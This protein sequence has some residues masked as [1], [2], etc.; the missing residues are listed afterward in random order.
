[1][2]V[3]DLY[4]KRRKRE[5]GQIPDVYAYDA[6]PQTFRMQ[7]FHIWGDAIGIPYHSGYSNTDR[8]QQTY[9]SIA[10]I[11]RRE[12]GKAVLYGH[13]DS[14]DAR[15]AHEEMKTWLLNET[16]VDKVL[17]GIEASFVVIERYCSQNNY[18]P[19]RDNGEIAKAAIDE[20][21]TRFNEHGL[22]YQY[23]HGKIVRTDSTFV[24]A[25]AVIPAL[26]I[27][28]REEYANAQTEFLNAFEHYRHGRKAEALTEAC[29]AFEST[30]KVIC[31][32]HQWAHSANATSKELIQV[33]Y[34]NGLIPSYW[35]T[36][37]AGLRSVLESGIPTPRN[38]QGGHG[39]GAGPS[40]NI[41]DNLV[42]YVL[43]MTA[44]T[45]LFLAE[46][47]RALP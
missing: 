41:P 3:Y 37:F 5:L 45:I 42:A 30:M 34:D 9:L 33:C 17:D 46:S 31:D 7:I 40:P 13:S 18:L 14:E 29:K 28:G 47:E 23:V 44:S 32:K 27:L 39:A 35:Q 21:N 12:F 19:R 1:M 43:H 16:N 22:G 36:H 25:E 6:L 20:L 38:R 24:H 4:S 2:P 11:L 15:N 26:D 8:I 10:K